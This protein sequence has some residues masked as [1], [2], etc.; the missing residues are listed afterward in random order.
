MKT[1]CQKCGTG[2]DYA[3]E[4]PN[5]CTKCGFN[6]SPVKSALAKT[7]P[8]RQK[9]ITP[10]EEETEDVES[11]ENIKNMS[12]LDVEIS[13][14]P[15]RKTKFKDIIGTRSDS[16]TQEDQI[17]VGPVDKKEFLE[18]FRKEAGFYPSRNQ[19]DEEE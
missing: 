15:D 12:C 6:F 13:A 5:F 7:I 2:I 18:S 3:Y 10:S 19:N 1:Y 8:P 17:Q 14:S 11:L 4:K 9:I 16:P